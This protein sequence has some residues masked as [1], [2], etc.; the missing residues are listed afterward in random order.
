M[1]HSISINGFFTDIELATSS[2]DADVL[3]SI[4]PFTILEVANVKRSI[5]FN[6]NGPSVW[7]ACF[8]GPLSDVALVFTPSMLFVL[9]TVFEVTSSIAS[10]VTAPVKEVLVDACINDRGE[11]LDLGT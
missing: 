4:C 11:L 2:A 5:C 10:E 8:C 6:Q 1:R 3:S 7:L 9:V